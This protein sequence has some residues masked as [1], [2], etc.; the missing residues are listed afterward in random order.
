METD[1]TD[2]LIFPGQ[3]RLP[4]LPYL[5][6]MAI[7][8]LST[9][10]ILVLLTSHITFTGIPLIPQHQFTMEVMK[11]ALPGNFMAHHMRP[12]LSI[13]KTPLQTC[14]LTM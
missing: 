7:P 13:Q 5:S 1:P 3:V 11:T 12:F 9:L 2:R 14:F 8:G 4:L 6:P 10:H